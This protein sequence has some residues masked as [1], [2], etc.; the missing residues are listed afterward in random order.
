MKVSLKWINDFVD[1]TSIDP[2]ELA[3]TLTMKTAETEGLYIISEHYSGIMAARI[4]SAEKI[5][6]RHFKCRVTADREYTV[7][8]GAPNTRAGMTAFFVKPGGMLDDTVIGEKEIAGVKSS[9][10]LLSLKELGIGSD[11]TGIYELPE[12][13]KPGTDIGDI[14]D[15]YDAIIEIDN[16]SLTHRPDLWGHYG[17]ARE[18]SAIYS[19]PLKEY[20]VFDINR[21]SSGNVIPIEIEDSSL[22][23]RYAGL[24]IENI[25]V[26]QSPLNIQVR[27]AHTE[28]VPRNIIVDLTN[29]VMTE[30]GQPM[31]SFDGDSVTAIKVAPLK[32]EID[33]M[34]LDKVNRKLPAGTLMID[35]QDSHVAIAGIMGGGNSEISGSSTSLFLESASFDAATIRRTSTNLSLRTDSSA[36]FEKSLDPEYA[37]LASL[38]YVKLLSDVQDIQFG[39]TLNDVNFNPFVNNKVEISC[40]TI[41]NVMG[42]D[43]SDERIIDILR[44]LAFDVH[45]N[46][47]NLIITAPTFRSTKD[48]SIKED[49]IEEVARIFG[50]ENITP[51]LPSQKISVP[52]FN[53]ER[54]AEHMIRDM[55]S[56]NEDMNEIETYS[57][58]NNSFMKETGYKADSPVILT[59][60]VSS[61]NT[62]LRD[63]ML[64]NMLMAVLN[65][66][67][68]FDEFS[69]YEM[70]SV[71]KGNAETRRLGI[72]TV[73]KKTK[74]G[75]RTAFADLK[76]IVWN[77]YNAAGRMPA[78]SQSGEHQL[79]NPGSTSDI[80]VDEHM[81]GYIGNVHPSF[82][83]LLDKKVNIAYCEADIS[84]F[85]GQKSD[86]QYIPFPQFPVTR[87][88]FSILKPDS[89]NFSELEDIIN[90]YKDPLI[91]E[92][93]LIDVFS[94]GNL[95]GFSSVTYRFTAVSSERTLNADDLNGIQQSFISYLGEKGLKLR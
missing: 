2:D 6:D 79:M 22:C 12:S 54:D 58:F 73:S 28:H 83:K 52:D 86:M 44:S 87:F 23:F 5:D 93:E 20:D 75:D 29:Y 15:F 25:R 27:L 80:M 45:Q 11:H 81:T 51:S 82:S 38:R 13:T 3:L 72:I 65:N 62:V 18:I 36:R 50:Y 31:H 21:I 19:L 9:G 67:K 85:T 84:T 53:K 74:D 34:T 43:I 64:P 61:E 49:I 33:Y 94:G 91:A 46:G 16:K 1:I 68:F 8:S 88:D 41:R 17:F 76:R 47:D 59:N 66:L 7:I 14:C 39:S 4:D 35:N 37:L 90:A 10:M 77:L 24:R 48:I 70:G 30:L 42:A 57:W 40:S 92:R 95:E 26:E 63:S 71:Y 69:L 55:L 56:F 60:P 32:K 78:L 89:M